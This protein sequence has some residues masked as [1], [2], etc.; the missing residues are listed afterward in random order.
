MFSI[1]K[2]KQLVSY[3]NYTRKYVIGFDNYKMAL[4]VKN[5]LPKYP[6]IELTRSKYVNVAVQLREDLLL[7]GIPISMLS[8]D[9]YIDDDALITF[10]HRH[11]LSCKDDFYRIDCKSIY[12]LLEYPF[13]KDIGLVT[14]YDVI[15][16]DIDKTIL[17]CNV[18]EPSTRV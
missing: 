5:N 1:T 17:K 18:I 12:E 6:V 10:H 15:Y 13:H 2:D 8:N 9:I 16:N 7:E 14:P 4:S 11:I 3:H